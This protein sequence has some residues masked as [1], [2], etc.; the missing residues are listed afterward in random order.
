ML[1]MRNHARRLLCVLALAKIRFPS[2][3]LEPKGERP[4]FVSHASG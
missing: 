4:R 2:Q 3:I 1:G